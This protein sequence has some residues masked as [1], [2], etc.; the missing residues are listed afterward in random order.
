G[1]IGRV[2]ANWPEEDV[3]IAVVTD[4]ER[5]LGIGDLGANG[6]GISVGKSVVYGAAGVQPHQILPI[7]VD[8][9][10]NADSVREDPLYIGLRQKRIRGGPYDSLL[11]ELVA[12]LRQRYGTSLLIHWEDLSAANS[13]RTLGRLQQQGIATFNDDIQSTGAATL[14]S[15]LGATRLPSVPPLRQQ[16]FLLFGAGQANIGAAQ[17][18]Q[19]RLE[20]EGLSLQDARSRIWLFDR[21][22]I[23]YDGRKGGSMTPE[24]AMFARSGSEAGWLEAL[25]NDLRKA[26]QQ[27]QP[28]ALIGAAAVRGAFSHEVLAQLSQ[29][30]QNQRG[31][32]GDV[33][34]VLALS[35]PTDKAECTAEEAFQACNDR[36]A[37]GSGT[38]FQPFTAADGLEVVPSQANNSFIFPGLGFGCIS[39]GATEITPDV[40]DAAS[41]AVAASLTQEEL[42]RRSIL[43]DTKRLREVALRVAAAVAL[44]AK[45]S[46]V[47]SS[48]NSTGTV[49][50]VAH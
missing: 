43:P 35:N 11:D 39:C 40:L 36:V 47:A 3:R 10:C 18:L 25:G 8:V 9:G 23:V 13:F 38:A 26:V 7:T 46:M 4:G 6:M 5:I 44:A 16:R 14:A 41:T 31:M 2:L 34:I 27:L 30:M 37:F 19:H 32:T 29:G 50:R 15:V 22:G 12:S 21:Q 42:Q 45:T 20:Q 49:V 17:L 1:Q 48:E 28:T 33:P 24:K